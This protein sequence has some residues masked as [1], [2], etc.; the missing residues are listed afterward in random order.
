MF[1]PRRLF[2]IFFSVILVITASCGR[3]GPAAGSPEEVLYLLQ[4]R[5]GTVE[6]MEL[7]SSD[8]I[9]EMERYMEASGMDRMAAVNT[10]S[11]IPEKAAYEVFNV[12]I[13]DNSCSLSIRYMK[14]GPEKSRGLVVNLTMVKEKGNWRI[15]R[16]E[17]FRKLLKSQ[18]NRGAENYL[19]R[20]R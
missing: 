17:D 15:D 13:S 19:E 9:R 18:V 8:T 11:F 3:K 2:N 7:F 4:E 20:I 12:K 10:L 16:S 6:V 14:E 5:Y 1:S